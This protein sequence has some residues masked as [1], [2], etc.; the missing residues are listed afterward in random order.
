[1]LT[2][3]QGRMGLPADQWRDRLDFVATLSQGDEPGRALLIGPPG[4]LPGSVRSGSG[5]DYRTLDG[6]QPTLTQ[7]YLSRPGPLDAELAAV[8]DQ[9]LLAG[10]DL[11]PGQAL[12]RLGIE[13]L[14][15]VPGSEFP[16]E[17]LS[18]QVDLV[19]RPVDA[20]LAVFQNDAYS[21]STAIPREGA[22][23]DTARVAGWGS[24]ALLV[25][26]SLAAYWGRSR[27]RSGIV[28]EPVREPVVVG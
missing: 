13:W 23:S 10:I 21:P 17:I 16:S 7:A 11:R 9:H 19:A 24:F 18:R 6:G 3:A 25:V 22:R 26:L 15:I 2:L 1:V 14:V 20:E 5:Y 28:P 4:S 27:D 8:I 12:S